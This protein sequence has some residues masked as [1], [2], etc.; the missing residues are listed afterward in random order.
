MLRN[1]RGED[2]DFANAELLYRRYIKDH[3]VDNAF[4]SAGFKF[5]RPSVNR[6]KYSEP[7]D[8][9]YSDVGEFD[10]FGVLEFPVEGI[11]RRLLD[12]AGKPYIFF[13]SHT[14]DENNYSHSE[15]W[16]EFQLEPGQQGEP[17]STTKKKFRT[18]LSQSVKV[19]IQA[20]I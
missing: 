13:P 10:G 17:S 20:S 9:I 14:P 11:P 5:P 2:Q 18:K 1:G 3:W 19:R 7:E 6:Q 8:V 16:C 4:A 15:I 12:G